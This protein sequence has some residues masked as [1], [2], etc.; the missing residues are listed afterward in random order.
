MI[1][2]QKVPNK[3]VAD[4]VFGIQVFK[5]VSDFDIRISDFVSLAS[6]HAYTAPKTRTAAYLN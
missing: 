2:N 5:F 4:F 1:K 6:W 3:A